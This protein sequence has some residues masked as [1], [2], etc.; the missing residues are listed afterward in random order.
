MENGFCLIFLM[1]AEDRNLLHPE[2]AKTDAR[3]LYAEG[4]SLAALRAQCYR[5]ASW[6]KHHDRYEGIKIVFHALANGQEPETSADRP[7]VLPMRLIVRESTVALPGRRRA[8]AAT[9][10]AAAS[11]LR[12]APPGR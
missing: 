5:A 7:S 4:Y 10:T 8:D 6:D 1:V 9:R 3:K 12:Q 2:K 11:S